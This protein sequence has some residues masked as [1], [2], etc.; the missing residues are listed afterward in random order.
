MGGRIEQDV[1]IINA[2]IL[3]VYGLLHSDLFNY[4]DSNRK[5]LGIQSY[6]ASLDTMEDVYLCAGEAIAKQKEISEFTSQVTLNWMQMS[7]QTVKI[8]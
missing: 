4:L 1:N 8:K 2:W 5:V 6:G 7:K 3:C